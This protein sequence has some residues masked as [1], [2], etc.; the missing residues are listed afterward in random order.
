M[1]TFLPYESFSES[2]RCFDDRRLA[3]QQTDA[4]Q[5]LYELCD[6]RIVHDDDHV[7]KGRPETSL[8]YHKRWHR[9]FAYRMWEGHFDALAAYAL[10]VLTERHR[11]KAHVLYAIANV[12]ALDANP[13]FKCSRFNWYQQT[14]AK[15]GLLPSWLG[16]ARLHQTHRSY[17]LSKNPEHY[18]KL[19]W[20][21]VPNL[22]LYWPVDLD[23]LTDAI[24]VGLAPCVTCIVRKVTQVWVPRGCTNRLG[25]AKCAACMRKALHRETAPC[26]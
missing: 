3:L 2:V 17:L 7:A 15:K 5:L 6:H 25:E 12:K 16:T 9:H 26:K 10:A 4:T 24:P 1:N 13:L 20:T 18:S 11:R 8:E 21:D 22:E 23:L 14:L 19:G